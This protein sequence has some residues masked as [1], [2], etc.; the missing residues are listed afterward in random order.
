MN[1]LT[2]EQVQ[3]LY[4]DSDAM[5]EPPYILRRI[6]GKGMRFYYTLDNQNNPDFYLSVTSLLDQQLPK[7]YG[8]LQWLQKHS[9][10]EIE[11]TRDSRATYG[12]LMHMILSDMLIDGEVDLENLDERTDMYAIEHGYQDLAEDWKA[13]IKKDVLAHAKF[14]QEK[15]VK[16]IAIEV[17]LKS[18]EMG[19]GGTVDLVCEMTFNK[20]RV[21][22][23]IDDKSNKKGNFYESH[24]IQLGIYKRMWEENYPDKPID[25]LFN[26]SSK[27]WTKAPTYT[28]K[29]QTGAK[30]IEKINNLLANQAIDDPAWKPRDIVEYQGTLKLDGDLSNN[31]TH[32][33]IQDAIRMNEELKSLEV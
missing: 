31:Y 1:G 27:D 30:S 33:P 7:G 18:D 2:F 8:F 11:H 21:R 19:L 4:F 12:T 5:V 23:I 3:S 16:P 20:K 22:A 25:M 9:F 24:E 10:E 6:D 14:I 29:N 32:M 13:E 28:L 17:P 15:E 26:Y